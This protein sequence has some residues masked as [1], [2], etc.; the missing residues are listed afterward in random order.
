MAS[1]SS[2]QNPKSKIQNLVAASPRCALCAFAV[3]K[4]ALALSIE[5]AFFRLWQAV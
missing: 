2:I 1:F 5:D 4:K 3:K